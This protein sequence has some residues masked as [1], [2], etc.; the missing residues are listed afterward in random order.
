MPKYHCYAIATASKYLGEF[1][2]KNK[3][4]AEDM[5]YESDECSMSLCHQCSSEA[6]LGDIYRIE[7]EKI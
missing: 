7:V 6:E 5:A 4:E 2:A 3:Q 1:E